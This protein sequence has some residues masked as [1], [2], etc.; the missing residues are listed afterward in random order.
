MAERLAELIKSKDTKNCFGQYIAIP[1]GV[2]TCPS[3]GYVVA[4][5][6]TGRLGGLRGGDDSNGFWINVGDR[7]FVRRGMIVRAT[8][9]GIYFIPIK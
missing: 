2:Y 5:T 8:A 3:D 6:G 9:T 1:I 7:I 4:E